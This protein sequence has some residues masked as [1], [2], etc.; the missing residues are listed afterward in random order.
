[1]VLWHNDIIGAS[2][3]IRH[4]SLSNI[5]G[6]SLSDYLRR[7]ANR[8]DKL[9]NDTDVQSLTLS[10]VDH[11]SKT[12][13]TIGSAYYVGGE[14][15]GFSG[16]L[17]EFREI[18]QHEEMLPVVFSSITSWLKEHTDVIVIDLQI[19]LLFNEEHD[20]VVVGKLYY[21]LESDED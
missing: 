16:R 1:M 10:T 6:E 20:G 8:I 21:S 9:P 17:Q 4:F 2:M 11:K 19:S 18:G 15:S 12:N 13:K 7:L 5:D 14:E 3:N